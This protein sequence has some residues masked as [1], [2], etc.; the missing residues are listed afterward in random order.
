MSRLRIGTVDGLVEPPAGITVTGPTRVFGDAALCADGRVLWHGSDGWTELASGPDLLCAVDAPGGL[1]IGTEGA[2]LTRVSPTGL[3]RIASFETTEGRDEWYTPW[4][5]APETRSLTRTDD[6]VLLASIHVGGIPRSDDGGRTWH[7]TIDI[8]ADVHQV[9]AVPGRADLVLAAAAV[10]FCRS[11]DGGLTWRVVAEGLHATYCRAVAIAGDAVLLSA[12]EGPRGRR[13]RCTAAASSP[14]ARSSGSQTGSRATS[15]RTRSMPSATGWSSE[16]ARRG[17]AVDGRRHDLG[18][19][20]RRPRARSPP[21]AS[22]P[23][24]TPPIPFRC[25]LNPPEGVELTPKRAQAAS[26]DLKASAVRPS[27]RPTAAPIIAPHSRM[28]WSSPAGSGIWLTWHMSAAI[29]LSI[30]SVVST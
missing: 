3:T 28:R 7:P 14:R 13:A 19:P 25:D 2:H 22:S 12:S 16:P 1:L 27:G 11:D 21:S 6:N 9:R 10:G 8:E 15:T 5:G 30:V 18:D 23:S 26:T 17:L 20:P 4:G 29:F 24:P